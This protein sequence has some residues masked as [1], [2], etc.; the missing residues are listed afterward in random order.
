MNE[1]D[2]KCNYINPFLQPFMNK[3]KNVLKYPEVN[4]QARANRTSRKTAPDAD[5]YIVN[6]DMLGTTT[7]FGETKIELFL[8]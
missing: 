3:D 8:N 1:N 6:Q 5:V 2:L 7:Y 4:P